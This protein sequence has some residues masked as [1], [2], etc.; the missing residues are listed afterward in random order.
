MKNTEK[1]ILSEPEHLTSARSTP[2][3]GQSR[4][5]SLD[6]HQSDLSRSSGL[7]RGSGSSGLSRG[8]GSSGLSRGLGSSGLSR[9][10][11]SSGLSRGSGSS[12]VDACRQAAVIVPSIGFWVGAWTSDCN[13][14]QSCVSLSINT[15]QHQTAMMHSLVSHC[16]STLASIRQQ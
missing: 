12:V 13:D 11:G 7:S 14:A 5:V 9:G 6:K 10:S 1:A 8:L 16:P 2:G 3:D 4:D 15:S